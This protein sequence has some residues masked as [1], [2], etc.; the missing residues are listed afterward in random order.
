MRSELEVLLRNATLVALAF[1]IA[2]G[3]SLYQV[4]ASVAGLITLGLQNTTPQSDRPPLS[5]GWGEHVVYFQPL[6]QDLITL[7]GVVAVVVVA[8]R[9]SRPADPDALEL[10]QGR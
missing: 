7:A 10:V 5:V 8:Q 2:L 1:V 3:W 9:H 6:L 4:G